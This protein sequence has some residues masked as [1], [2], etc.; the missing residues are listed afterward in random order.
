MSNKQLECETCSEDAP[1]KSQHEGIESSPKTTTS[2]GGDTRMIVNR[3]ID[4]NVTIT[5]MSLVTVYALY[6]DDVRKLAFP[7][8]A[9]VAFLAFSSI[10]FAFFTMEITL[11]CW[12]RDEYL[13]L[14]DFDKAKKVLKGFSMRGSIGSWFKALG[15]SLEF[16]SFYFWLDLISTL[17]MALEVSFYLH[18]YAIF[19]NHV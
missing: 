9:D 17:S 12:C 18:I 14:P 1:R 11:L 6:G 2:L 4:S 10:A 19:H 7:P 16:G 3:V 5:T 8:S 13:K 15:K